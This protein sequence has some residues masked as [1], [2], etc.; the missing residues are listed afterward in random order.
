MIDAE[1]IENWDRDQGDVSIAEL[2]KPISAKKM[3]RRALYAQGHLPMTDEEA[4]VEQRK[5][6][7][8]SIVQRKNRKPRE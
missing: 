3:P 8:Q 4:W 6:T 5:R 7:A 1:Q 2:C